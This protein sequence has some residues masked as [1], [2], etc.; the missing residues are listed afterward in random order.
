M[1]MR[2]NG[3]PI[4]LK[5]TPEVKRLFLAAIRQGYHFNHAAAIAGVSYETA[6]R[7]RKND[8][9]FHDEVIEAEGMFVLSTMQKMDKI[10]SDNLDHWRWRLEKRFPDIF[11]KQTAYTQINAQQNNILLAPLPSL[12][13]IIEKITA[14]RTKALAEHIEREKDIVT[15]SPSEY[16]DALIERRAD[17]PLPD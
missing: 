10:G 12:D 9:T 4:S 14:L 13:E 1:P 6:R 2:S 17:G 8:A 7:H 5:F 11:G 3:S 15:L 16:V